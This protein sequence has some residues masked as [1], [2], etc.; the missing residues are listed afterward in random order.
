VAKAV[1]EATEEEVTGEVETM[2][3]EEEATGEEEAVAA[4]A[5]E[6][7]EGGSERAPVS[8]AR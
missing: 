4:D 7:K 2:A 8:Q 5:S 6:G 1:A 3:A